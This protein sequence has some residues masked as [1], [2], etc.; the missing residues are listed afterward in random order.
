MPALTEANNLGDLLKYEAPNL[1][2]RDRVTVSAGQNLALGAVVGSVTATGQVK[3]LDPSASDG[4][5]IPSGVLLGAID[6]RLA[7]RPDGLIVGRH[8]VVADTALVWPAG[9]TPAEKNAALATLKSLGI[10]ARPSV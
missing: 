9:I 3:A 10:L 7:D 6:A 1:Y 8:A 5:E 4:T 2:S